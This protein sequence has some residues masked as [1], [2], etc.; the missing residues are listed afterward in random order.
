MLQYKSK[1][2]LKNVNIICFIF[3]SKTSDLQEGLICL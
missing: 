1:K 2:V 3:N